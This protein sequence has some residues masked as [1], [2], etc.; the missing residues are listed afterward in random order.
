ME[1]IAEAG[2]NHNGNLSDALK[3]VDCAISAQ[4]S[5]IKFQL[6]YPDG[7][8]VKKY[9]DKF[10][11]TSNDV[12]EQR[13]SE[14]VP[15]EILSEVWTYA[16]ANGIDIF[17]SVFCALG[18]DM[19]SKLGSK[20]VKI[21]STDLNNI[22]LIESCLINFDR[23]ILST[24]MST[25]GEIDSVINHISKN[26]SIDA[27]ELMHC[28]SSYPCPTEES[29]LG[30][31]PIL[32]SAFGLEVG[33]S[34]HTSCN[35]SAIAAA[36]LGCNVFEKHFTY[37]NSVSGF[38]HMYA[39][40]PSELYDYCRSLKSISPALKFRSALSDNEL[41][42]KNRARRGIYASRD[43]HKGAVLTRDDFLIVR[44]SNSLNPA[45][46]NNLIGQVASEPLLQ[47]EAVKLSSGVFPDSINQDAINYWSREM[48]EKGMTD[49]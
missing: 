26:G 14:V 32:K 38:D 15:Y 6:I 25:L 1:I 23:C 13:Q 48:D 35:T 46:V 44:P 5:S 16:N 42:T 27:L 20:T 29:N 18:V 47:Y 39:S 11:R 12:F 24:G 7:L 2:S 49:K 41:V 34:D 3:L 45:D 8:Y 4:A 17:A 9:V 28:V 33:Y 31:I 30:R 22:E 37:D 10:K 43:I 40:S 36:A 21:A 19:L